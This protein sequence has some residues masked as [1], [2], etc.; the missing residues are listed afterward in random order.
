MNTDLVP[1]LDPTA[2]PAPPW[3]FHVLLV[4]TFVLHALFMNLALGGTILAAISQLFAGGRDGEHRVALARRLMGINTYAI[5]LAITTG[6]AP[7]LFVQVLYQQYFYTATILIGWVWLLFLVMLTLGYYAAYAYKFR[8]APA[9]GSGGTIW[10]MIAAVNFLLIAM[11]HV[12]VNLIHSQP[13]KWAALAQNPWAILADPAY[14]P[15]L[16]HFVLA[17][18]GF[19]SIVA[20]WWAARQAAAGRDVERNTQ[21]ARYTW[22]WTLW[23]TLLQIADGFVLLMVLPREVLLGLMRGGAA[24]MVPLTV[25]IVLGIGMLMMLARVSQPTQKLGAVTGT[26]ATMVLTIV[27]MSITRHQLRVIYLQP[28]TSQYEMTSAPQWGNF[29]LFALLLVAGLATVAYMIK[30][31]LGNPARGEEAA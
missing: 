16:L 19:T 8:G 21:I 30:Q 24:T 13:G 20:T 9:K 22:R 18:I 11:V 3:L 28:V 25:A 31:V 23:T 26:L 12:A 10:L 1:A 14:F 5:S 27:V 15:R 29:V 6:I 2:I 4:F 17:A 7:L